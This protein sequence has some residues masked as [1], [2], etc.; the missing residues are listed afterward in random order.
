MTEDEKVTRSKFRKA[1]QSPE[2]RFIVDHL[3]RVFSAAS[4]QVSDGRIAGR[5]EVIQYAVTH[6]ELVNERE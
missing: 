2:G 3:Q 5:L 4:T 6:G 1:V